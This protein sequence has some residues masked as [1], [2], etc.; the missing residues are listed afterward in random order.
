MMLQNRDSIAKPNKTDAGNGSYGI[1][2]VIDASRS[3]SPD[4]GRS[5]K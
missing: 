3:P 1:C 4:P 2:R 5:A